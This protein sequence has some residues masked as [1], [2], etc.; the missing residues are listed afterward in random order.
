MLE[1]GVVPLNFRNIHQKQ[2]EGTKAVNLL[3]KDYY[4][5]KIDYWMKKVLKSVDAPLAGKLILY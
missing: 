5:Y 2:N 3:V 4:L 1:Q